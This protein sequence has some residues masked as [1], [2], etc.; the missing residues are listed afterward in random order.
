MKGMFY[1]IY[2]IFEEMMGV[3][4]LFIEECVIIFEFVIYKF[5]IIWICM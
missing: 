2:V 1:E 4:F 3:F 5:V